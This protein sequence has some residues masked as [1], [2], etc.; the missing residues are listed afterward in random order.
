MRMKLSNGRKKK[1]R[2]PPNVGKEL[3]PMMLKLPNVRIE[4]P[5]VRK[6]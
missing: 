3:S 5:K 2:E 1:V 4:S 6:K